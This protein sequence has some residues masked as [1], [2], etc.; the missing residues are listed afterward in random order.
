[1]HPNPIPSAEDQLGFLSTLQRLFAEGDFTATYKFALLIALADL[2]VELGADDGGELLLSTRQIGERFILMY[3]RQ[4]LPYGSGRASTSP[5]VLLQNNGAQAAVISA[6]AQFRSKCGVGTAQQARSLPEYQA[7]LGKVAQTVSAQPLNYL[8]NFGGATNAFL[9]ERAGPGKVRLKPGV[10][11]CLRR[12]HPL[13]QGLARTHWVG[14]VKGNRG[15]RTILGEANDLENFLFAAS[16]QSL[17]AMADGLRKVDGPKCFYCGGTVA[18]GDV[19][20]FI[21]FSLYSRD[22]AHNF[23]LAHPSCNRSKSDTLAARAHLERWLERFARRGDAI[24][25]IGQRAGLLV[26]AQV[27]RKIAAWGYTGAIASGGNAWIASAK[28]ES[29]DSS[30]SRCFEQTVSAPMPN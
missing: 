14:H 10:A 13:V 15:N 17:L 18:T 7:L 12:F 11:Y 5:G 8:Q 28:Y 19:D 6:L 21:P 20:H 4:A 1:M 24:S 23:V 16:R 29:V 25:E 27:S 30:Y 9:Y 2:A 22:L 26:D 3:W